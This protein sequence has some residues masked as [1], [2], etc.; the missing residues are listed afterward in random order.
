MSLEKELIA[1]YTKN[2]RHLPWREDPLPYHVYLSE[3]MLQQTRVDTVKAYYLR[4]L[5][6]YPTLADLAEAEEEEVLKLWEGLG[7]YS[8]GRNLLKS[9]KAMKASYQSEVP[10]SKKELLTLPGIGEYTS[11]AILAIAYHQKEIAVDGNLIR[12][13]SRLTEEK[14]EN[15]EKMKERCDAYFRKELQKEDPSSFNQA[16]MDLGEMV[17]LPHSLPLCEACPFRSFCKAHQDGTV[18]SY[19]PEKKAK[20]KKEEDLTVLVLSHEGKI[21][22]EKRPEEGLLASLYQYPFLS[23][24]KTAEEVRALLEKEG[25]SL[26][27][28]SEIGE[29][30][31]VFSHLIWHLTAYSI[32]LSSVPSSSPYLWVD[33]KELKKRYALPSAFR[34]VRMKEGK[35]R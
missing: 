16:L 10:S 13:F 29:H 19:P 22:L 9:A 5:K 35:A 26:A 3:I 7:Y 30:D 12:V 23:G 21:A 24:K 6:R 2:R 25:Y 18:M 27:S 33:P 20:A 17:C 15:P 14:E 31:H 11:K 28:L 1:W 32:A 34:F 4:F 8:R